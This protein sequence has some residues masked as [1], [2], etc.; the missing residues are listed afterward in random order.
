MSIKKKKPPE[1]SVKRFKRR[2]S[3]TSTEVGYG[4]PWLLY[5]RSS[6]SRS[7]HRN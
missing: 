6:E 3:F 7:E 5:L 1:A 2:A 4:D